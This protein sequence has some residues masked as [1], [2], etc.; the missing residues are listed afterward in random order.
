ME[1]DSVL[2]FSDSSTAYRYRTTREL[3]RAYWLFRL[4]RFPFA[5]PLGTFL[6]RKV[7]QLNLSFPK[8]VVK[9]TFFHHFLGGETLEEALE[10]AHQL[11]QYGIKILLDYAVEAEKSESRYESIKQKNI[12]ILTLAA[13]DDA[14]EAVA[15]KPSSIGNSTVL[16][17]W[18]KYNSNL[19]AHDQEALHAF[20]TRLNEICSHGYQ[21]NQV[22]SIDA[23]ETWIQGTIDHFCE[24]MMERYNK[25]RPIVQIT[26]QMYRKDRLHYLKRL[27]EMARE[28]NFHLSVRLV[29]G[30]YLEKERKRAQE[31][32]YESPIHPTKEATDQAYNQAIDYCL[33]HFPEITLTIATHNEQSCLFAVEK[34]REYNIEPSSPQITFSQLYGMADYLSFP[35]AEAG[36][37]V[38]KYLPYGPL[39]A[40]VEYLIRRAQENS[41]IQGHGKRELEM[42]RK[43]LERRKNQRKH[44]HVS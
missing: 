9:H 20:C 11:N 43:E 6:L 28:K 8:K 24:K 21:V 26:L 25:V 1:K 38:L 27:H 31:L 41:S 15:F 2:F 13:Q 17:K 16:E 7:F 42:I 35:L 4:L 30:A 14:V 34:M 29:R 12:E 37:R 23:E 10:V 3:K 19:N 44:T 32:G 18:Q 5:L 22:I 36:Y 33:K 40:A 39:E